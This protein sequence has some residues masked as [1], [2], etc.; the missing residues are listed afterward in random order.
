MV[1]PKGKA[2]GL[3][4][5]CR[6]LVSELTV[7]QSLHEIAFASNDDRCVLVQPSKP[8]T[9]AIDFELRCKASK[10]LSLRC[11]AI[12]WSWMRG[13]QMGTRKNT[14]CQMD[15]YHGQWQLPSY[16][17][18]QYHWRTRVATFAEAVLL[19]ERSVVS[20]YRKKPCTQSSVLH[21]N[22]GSCMFKWPYPIRITGGFGLK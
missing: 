16:P 19:R 3:S 1:P 14:L 18:L 8:Y 10:M 13:L 20:A 6:G 11:V 2:R 17:R 15:S 5:A 7:L 21:S 4:E 22:R 9:S 12:V